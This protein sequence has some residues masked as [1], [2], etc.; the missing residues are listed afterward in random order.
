MPV[1][2]NSFGQNKN[3][4]RCTIELV[5]RETQRQVV[6]ALNAQPAT[7]LQVDSG[8]TDW[9]EALRATVLD[10][11]GG[12]WNLYGPRLTGLSTVRAGANFRGGSF[13]AGEIVRLLDLR[14]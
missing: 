4:I 7:V 5:S 1:K 8:S 6:V 2:L 12:T 11:R 14:D 3:G 9:I 10:D 13:P